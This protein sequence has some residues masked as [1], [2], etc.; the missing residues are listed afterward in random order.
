MNASFKE[1]REPAGGSLTF[2]HTFD[3]ATQSAYLLNMWR[4][5]LLLNCLILIRGSALLTTDFASQ[6]RCHFYF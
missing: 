2:S 3:S 5:S 4:Y 6:R 1:G